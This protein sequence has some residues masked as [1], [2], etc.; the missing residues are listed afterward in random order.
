MSTNR[1]ADSRQITTAAPS[2]TMSNWTVDDIRKSDILTF[3]ESRTEYVDTVVC[4]NGL[5]V[6]LLDEAFVNDLLVVGNITGSG[7]IYASTAFS[8]S[9][10]TL[11]DGS[12]YLRGLNGITVTNHPEGYIT[13]DGSGGGSGTTY[14]AA[15]G[16]T[17]SNSNVFEADPDLTTIG[18]D[19][20]T[21][22]TTLSTPGTLTVGS[23]LVGPNFNGAASVTLA[24]QAVSGS[25]VVVTNAGIDF[26]TANVSAVS[27]SASD[28]VLVSNG[29]EMVKT[30]VQNLINLG[31]GSTNLI[32][33]DAEYLVMSNH[34]GLTNEKVFSATDGVQVTSSSSGVVVS[35][36]VKS[37]GGLEIISGELAVK[38]GDF[39]GVGLT[40]NSG[41]GRIDLNLGNIAGTG[42]TQNG[43]VL[44]IDF[45][46][47]VNQVARGSNTIG[48]NA[49][50]GL[51]LGGAV[52]IG[53]TNS[54]I[55]LA[56]EYAGQDNIVISARDG[57]GVN[58]DSQNDYLLL[59]DATDGNVKYVTPSQLGLSSGGGGGGGGDDA[60]TIGAA[61]DGTYDDGLFLD[62]TNSTPVGTAIDRF[63]EMLALL[64]PSPAPSIS[65]INTTTNNGIDAKLSFGTSNTG[66]SAYADSGNG[67]GMTPIDTNEIYAAST[68]GTSERLGIFTTATNI[69][70]I[71]N[72]HV[73][74]DT[75]SNGIVNFVD[76]AFGNAEVG[77]LKLFVNDMT[78]PVHTVDLSSFAGSGD[79][80]TTSGADSLTNNSGFF[81]VS[82]HK[83]ATSS[84]NKI[85]N[86][87]KHRT[88]KY[89]IHSTH[90]RQGWN[91]ARVIHTVN[92]V[93]KTTNFI[94]WVNDTDTTAITATNTAVANIVGSD[95]FV[96]SGIKYFKTA[97]FDYNT[98]INNAHRAIHTATPIVFNSQYG[99]ITTATDQDS[100][101]LL[102]TFPGV[103]SGQDYTKSIT[104]TSSGTFNVSSSGFPASGLLNAASTLSL[105]VVHPNTAKNQTGLAAT[106]VSG[107]LMWY[108]TA[109][110]TAL[111]EDFN[112]ETWRQQ[113]GNYATQGDVYA[114]GGYVTPWN[115]A[116]FVNSTD[117]GH[118]TGLVQYQGQLRAP[119][120]TLLNG[121]FASVTNGPSSNAN[122][123]TI[124]TGVREYIRAFKK[125]DAGVV[126]DIRLTLDGDATIISNSASFDSNKI[127]VFVKVPGSTGWMDMHGAFVLGSD[128][129]NDGA[130][131]GTFTSDISGS[132]H[133]Y[134]SFGIDTVSQND[135]ILIKIQADATWTGNLNSITVRFGASSGD[136]TSVPDS[137]TSINSTANDG[138]DAKLSFG[139]TQ[140]IPTSDANDPYTNVSGTNSLSNVDI[141][142][143][144]DAVTDGLV[145]GVYDGSTV[146]TGIVNSG[147]AGD[148]DNFAQYSIRYGNEGT[149]KVFVND[150][151]KHSLNLATF[152]G[153]GAPGAG[154]AS[155]VNGNGTGFTNI[156]TAQYTTWSDGIPDYRYNV[157]TMRWSVGTQ[158]QRAGHNWVRI[159]HQVSGTNYETNYVEWVN[160]PTG[161]S[162]S[163]SNV[164]LADFT[165][166]NTSHLSGIEYFNSP[167]TT[168]KYRVANMHRNVYH[169]GTSALGFIGLTNV[170]LTNL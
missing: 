10:Q 164:D 35:A 75:Y 12:D 19:S 113:S 80:G 146:H 6:G 111:F 130:H 166:S 163:F 150:V 33:Q 133:N 103:A 69:E 59:H 40:A 106:S 104:V 149:I 4:P 122:Y 41:T 93:D 14:T 145:R 110:P 131:V 78:T 83:H 109:A 158:D 128:G 118:N 32:P 81:D 160:D 48:I 27:V 76:D 18:F 143:P 17:L 101:N 70:G 23:G 29:S 3:R 36:V 96:L 94:E 165:D 135:Y 39:V 44:D 98:T 117:S 161:G 148:T 46:T 124:T 139:A 144:Y 16:M 141:N 114:S 73:G 24:V 107:L 63:N 56:I 21:K 108:P 91:Y 167:S 86:I 90:Q 13:I 126:R 155:D 138:A 100:V 47:T 127:K 92:S 37:N 121:N 31:I 105:D 140:S 74:T 1:K 89:R 129:D 88:A 112:S 95:Q 77:E 79:P 60:G 62:F 102:S 147:E 99:S 156:S 142:Q 61:E 26:S 85:F 65:T 20:N 119:R 151:E 162:V 22:L 49:G 25:P 170:S 7:V 42:M 97:S 45:G 169:K 82:T 58:I 51:T 71:I 168:F 154:N 11:I 52:T 134:A 34:S 66:G 38:I 68:Q 53:H 67:A 28:Y 120:N 72:H 15:R 54:L 8:G 157:R 123:S 87:F 152:V 159:V 153:S 137:C 57:T 125:E 50:D 115:S 2:A 30:T 64:A 55:P 5:Q 136:E 116:T 84:D 132:V 43:S 9:L